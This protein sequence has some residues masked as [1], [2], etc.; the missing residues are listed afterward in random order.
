MAR[1]WKQEGTLPYRG[2]WEDFGGVFYLDC[3]DGHHPSHGSDLM[4]QHLSKL[5]KHFDMHIIGGW[6]SEGMAHPQRE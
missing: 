1:G 4:E 2:S 3:G 6:L 5:I